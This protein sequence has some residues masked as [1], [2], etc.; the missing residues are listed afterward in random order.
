MENKERKEFAAV[1]LD[2]DALDNVSGGVHDYI[3]YR[4][5]RL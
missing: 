3:E 2:D 4:V 5:Y 1:E